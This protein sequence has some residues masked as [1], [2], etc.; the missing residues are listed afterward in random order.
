MTINIILL[1]S[2][3]KFSSQINYTLTN[4]AGHVEMLSP[5]MVNRYLQDEK[6]TPALV[7]EHT[8]GDI[9]QS[10]NGFIVFDDSILDKNHSRHIE[11]VR[12]QYSGKTHGIVRGI[13]LVNCIYINPEIRSQHQEIL[14][15]K[16]RTQDDVPEELLFLK[17]CIYFSL[18]LVILIILMFL[19]IKILFYNCAK[20]FL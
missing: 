6:L 20:L 14:R 3:R 13:G 10:E 7:W 1:Y 9:R 4:F 8:K 15:A 11:S 12:W 17:K 19:C 16:R 18:F 5:D 2:E